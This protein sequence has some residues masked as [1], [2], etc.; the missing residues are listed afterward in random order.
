MGSIPSVAG[1]V[2]GKRNELHDW[3]QLGYDGANQFKEICERSSLLRT[4]TTILHVTDTHLG[5]ATGGYGS[6]QWPIDCSA[7][8]EREIDAAISLGV[9][10]VVH[11]GDLFHNDRNGIPGSLVGECRSQFLRLKSAD[12]SLYYI[13]G[14]HEREAGKDAWDK[15]ERQGLATHLTGSPTQIG[16]N[17]AIYGADYQTEDWW[18]SARWKPDPTKNRFTILALHQSL[19]PL[20]PPERAECT[21]SDIL[22]RT[23]QNSGFTFDGIALG[24]P[25]KRSIQQV[26]NCSVICG[27]PP[28]QLDKRR[29]RSP[30]VGLFSLNSDGL[31]YTRHSIS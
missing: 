11:T 12:I 13:R 26:D 4:G 15:F 19:A 22:Q 30:F 20:S 6:N 21:A 1:H 2:S 18:Q 3:D 7:G 25:H 9:D 24:H 14:N 27:E 23:R 28:E 10:A 8:F 5:K 31:A 17:V 16:D 29:E